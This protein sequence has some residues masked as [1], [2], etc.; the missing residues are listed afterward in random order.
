[1]TFARA[2][3]PLFL[4]FKLPE[5]MTTARTLYWSDYDQP[6]LRLTVYPRAKSNQHNLLKQL[7]R[8]E[9]EVYYAAPGFYR[10]R[11]FGEYFVGNAMVRNSAFFSL[12]DLPNIT[13]EE[14]HHITYRSG[15]DGFRWHSQDD[16]YSNAAITGAR[17]SEAMARRLEK[18]R[19]LGAPYFTGLRQSLVEH[20]IPN[21]PA[22]TAARSAD[23]Q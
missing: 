19:E 8:T 23:R 5:Y 11:D 22:T 12:A 9:P 3:I 10:E 17:W 15:Q 7:A 13:D 4:Q 18:P 21:V 6:H 16:E 20:A 1:M 14:P 2:G